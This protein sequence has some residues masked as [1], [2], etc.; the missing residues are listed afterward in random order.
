MKIVSNCCCFGVI[1]GSGKL[2]SVEEVHVPIN[3]CPIKRSE[4]QRKDDVTCVYRSFDARV[5]PWIL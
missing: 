4:G 1:S 3:E 2:L 5:P